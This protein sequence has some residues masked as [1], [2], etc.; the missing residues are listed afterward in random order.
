MWRGGFVALSV[1]SNGKRGGQVCRRWRR[2]ESSQRQDHGLL[3]FLALCRDKFLLATYIHSAYNSATISKAHWKS[4]KSYR[5]AL[6]LLFV[7]KK[8]C[9]DVYVFGR[10]QTTPEQFY[11]LST[12]ERLFSQYVYG[13]YARFKTCFFLHP[14]GRYLSKTPSHVTMSVTLFCFFSRKYQY[15]LPPPA[16]SSMKEVYDL[17]LR[18]PVQLHPAACSARSRPCLCA[19]LPSTLTE[20]NK[21]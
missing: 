18:F 5:M 12:Q 15:C 21:R 13:V 3:I 20:K 10:R 8:I 1:P 14:Y 9:L 19:L 11:D 6:P 17:L 4:T 16:G 7:F 2:F